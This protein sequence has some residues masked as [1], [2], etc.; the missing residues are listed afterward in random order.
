MKEFLHHFFLPRHTN[1]YRAGILHHKILLS[2]ILFF[3]SAG[4]LMSYLRTNFPSVL[5]TFTDIS[6]QQL[7]LLTNEKR[8]ENGLPSLTIND[9][10]SQAALSKASDMLG[11][12][13]WA[14]NSPDGT[15]PWVFIRGAGYNYI[16]AGENLA[17]GFNNAPDVINA[18]MASEA[19]RKNML[20]SNYQNV[21]F[22]VSTGKLSGEDTV[23]VVEFL[24]STTYAPPAVAKEPEKPATVAVVPGSPATVAKIDTETLGAQKADSSKPKVIVAN[25]LPQ[26]KPL[27]NSQTLS[28]VSI[29]LIM[30]MFILAFILDMMI[31]ERKKVI[32]FVGHNLDHL[33]LFSLVL[34]I[35]IILA[36]GVII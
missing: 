3:F 33:F 8:Q 17:R 1:N 4:F 36:R 23:L 16:Y 27:V 29:R 35:I 21:G 13:Y 26:V 20:S 28:L 7:L 14:H 30:F 25:S 24:G 19:H 12:D 6:I 2:F 22:A 15:P 34:L 11:K 10:L 32:R 18:W 5:G 31:V 9:N